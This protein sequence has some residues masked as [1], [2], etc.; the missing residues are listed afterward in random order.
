M[1]A[2]QLIFLWGFVMDCTYRKS[3]GP[4]VKATKGKAYISITREFSRAKVSSIQ[5]RNNHAAISLLAIVNGF[6]VDISNP[7]KNDCEIPI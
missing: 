4:Y 3:K 6:L 2:N 5:I 7:A 1:E